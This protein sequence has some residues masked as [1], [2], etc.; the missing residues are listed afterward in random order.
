M[1]WIKHVPSLK[2]YPSQRYRELITFPIPTHPYPYKKRR[3]PLVIHLSWH[4]ATFRDDMNIRIEKK[5]LAECFKKC[6]CEYINPNNVGKEFICEK[7]NT[8]V[9]IESIFKNVR[10][11]EITQVKVYMV[12]TYFRKNQLC[13]IK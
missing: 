12:K 3:E 13:N 7:Y 6:K 2:K 9:K 8:K 5:Y 11:K 1:K 4:K 10:T